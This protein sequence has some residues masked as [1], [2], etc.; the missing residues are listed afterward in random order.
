VAILFTISTLT[1]GLYYFTCVRYEI[2]FLPTL[3]LLAVMG[4]L[5]LEHALASQP[6][7]RR[8]ARWS[9]S[10][11]LAFSVIFNLLACV[12][13]H[14]AAHTT[15]GIES[16][17][18]GKVSEAIEQYE[19]ALRLSP[20]YPKV[21]FNLGLALERIGH[22]P[23]AVKEYEESLCLNP[24]YTK[25]HRNQSPVLEQTVH[26]HEQIEQ[27]EHALRSNPD[28]VEARNALR[29]LLTNQ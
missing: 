7:W 12:E 19:Q 16:F 15:M 27:Y 8:A 1:L 5:G 11:L 25:A 14:A 9:W 21:H 4:I 20:D 2:E 6:G 26:L 17:Q 28:D 13:Y 18:A 29:R 24:D 10:A 22:V 23:E 3:L